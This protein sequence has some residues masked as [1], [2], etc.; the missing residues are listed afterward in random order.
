MDKDKKIIFEYRDLPAGYRAVSLNSK[1]K[2]YERKVIYIKGEP[3]IIIPE[4]AIKDCRKIDGCVY[5]APKN[6]PEPKLN[7]LIELFNKVLHEKS[8]WVSDEAMKK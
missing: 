3:Q 2:D 8:G 5:F 1:L 7:E 6:T 4:M